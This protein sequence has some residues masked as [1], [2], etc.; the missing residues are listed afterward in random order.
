[1]LIGQ[2]TDIHI[3]FDKGNPEEHNMLRL[4]A[5]LDKLVKGPNRPDLLLLSGDLTED[6]APEDYARLA[7]AVSVCPFP[8][9]PMV[10]NHD[11]RETLR[12]AFPQTPPSA[13][14]FVHYVL[15]HG[16]LRL[17]VLDTLEVG[18]HGG[19][20]CEVRAAWLA[21]TLAE[22]PDKPTLVALHH[23]PFPAGIPWMD[24]DERE[25]WV[26]RLAGAL[27]GHNQVKGLIAGH[28]HRT[29]LS[30]WNDL[31]VLVC[32]STA[33]AVGLDLTPIDPATPDGRVLITDEPPGYCLHQWTGK[34][35][36]T[37]F[38]YAGDYRVFA[39]YDAKLQGMIQEMIA[40][41]PQG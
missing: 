14:G 22:A 18:R 7:E 39:R 21:A 37:H 1:M 28:L 5:A 27:D 8:V 13:D 25:P 6:G 29:I 36:V 12:A 33:P 31:P 24:T 23:P 35:V 15:D 26:A 4:R 32:P 34:D 20:F 38:E 17:V 40:E 30:H 10:G 11:V 41:R 2:L 19:G 3:G 16:P 9:W